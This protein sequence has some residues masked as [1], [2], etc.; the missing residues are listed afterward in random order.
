MTGLDF[1]GRQRLALLQ[2]RNGHSRFQEVAPSTGSDPA[3]GLSLTLDAA[4]RVGEVRVPDPLLVRTAEQLRTAVRTAFQEADEARDRASRVAVGEG[5]PPG[6]EID[7]TTLL[8]TRPPARDVVK[9]TRARV[10]SGVPA[11]VAPT[12]SATGSSSNGYLSV[13]VGPTGVVED[14]TADAEWLAAAASHYLEAA[15]DQAFT[16]AAQLQTPTQDGELR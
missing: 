14:V 1:A 6:Q 7:V 16:V 10:A 13:V 15:L 3:T 12:L 9:R 8:G 5:P 2:E 11:A 4:R